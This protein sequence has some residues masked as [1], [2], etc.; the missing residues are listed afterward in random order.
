MPAEAG[1]HVTGQRCAESCM[2]PGP[3]SGTEAGFPGKTLE[4]IAGSMLAQNGMKIRDAA[5]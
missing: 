1:I 5:G 3:G 2:G 4:C